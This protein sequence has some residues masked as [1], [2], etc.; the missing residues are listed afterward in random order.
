LSSWLSLLEELRGLGVF[1]VALIGGEP[2]CHPYMKPLLEDLTDGPMRFGVYTNGTL[3]DD[4]WV[5]LL[6]ATHRCS[7]VT[8]SLD[9]FEAYHDGIRGAGTFRRALAG[10]ERVSAA[11]I[12]VKIAGVVSHDNYRAVPEFARFLET[13]PIRE[14]KFTLR[15][16]IAHGEDEL[17]EEL[18]L[19]ENVEFFL[20]MER[21][22]NELQKIS[23]SSAP[24]TTLNQLR[25][26]CPVT[27]IAPYCRSPLTT[28]SVLPDG[29]VPI[30]A[31]YDESPVAGWIGK[32]RVIDIWNG[33]VM[34]E[35]RQRQRCGK[36]LPREEC[37]D[38]EYRQ[39]CRK[40]C[41]K[42]EKFWFC[43]KEIA[44]AMAKVEQVVE[45]N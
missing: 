8:I 32:Q 16:D 28:I 22:R 20:S 23:P 1:S 35:F 36:E 33:S 19:E 30:C 39:S 12:P 43:Y 37:G 15:G 38:C 25:H 24:L 29:S 45:N 34:N 5:E 4:M 31:S 6:Q 26:P 40:Y 10:I 9:G 21:V 41:S 13:L 11:G 2:L 3:L 44:D 18:S 14:Y 17:C 7:H 42:L 27:E